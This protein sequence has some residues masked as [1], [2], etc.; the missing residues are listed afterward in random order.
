M[1][2]SLN[3]IPMSNTK[4]QFN[5]V[6]TNRESLGVP[7]AGYQSFTDIGD[8]YQNPHLFVHVPSGNRISKPWQP[9]I[10][11]L[12]DF[13]ERIYYYFIRSGYACIIWRRILEL[14]QIIFMIGFTF[15]LL[16]LVDYGILFKN[17]LP[18]R[19]N[20][21]S[22]Q[23][24]KITIN[25]CLIPLS[26]VNIPSYEVILLVF[27]GAYWA[28][29]CC[30]TILSVRDYFAIRAFFIEVLQIHDPSV[31]TWQEVQSR[32]IS[33]QSQC[34][35]REG[36]LD[37]LV[38][39]NRL[40]RRTNYMLALINKGV[41]P[42][43][44]KFPILGEVIYLS[45]GLEFNLELLLFR[46]M[47]S[48]FEKNWKLRDEVKLDRIECA[49]RFATR[50][51]VLGII[52]IIL[53]PFILVWH[54][55]YAL[56]T[57]IEAFKRDPTIFCLRTWSRYG[58]WFTR[59][60]NELDHELEQRLNRA[61]RPA[62]RYM[63]SFTSPLMTV[64]A[65]FF[66]FIAATMLSALFL[67]TVW[68]EDVITVEHVLTIVT[69]LGGVIALSRAFLPDSEPKRYTQ[70]ELDAAIVQHIH[71]RAH[72]HPAHTI[73]ARNAMSNIFVYKST[74]IIEELLSPII[75]PFIL[76][77]HLRARSLEIV[78]FFRVYTLDLADIGDVCSFS[79]FNFQQNGHRIFNDP[80][81]SNKKHDD[82]VG[83]SATS[84]G[85]KAEVLPDEPHTTRN[86]KLEL[87]LINFKLTNP[88]WQPADN[89]QAQFIERFTRQSNYDP[90]VP[91]LAH[92]NEMA[93]SH[94]TIGGGDNLQI[95]QPLTQS[96]LMKTSQ[97]H[98][99]SMQ[100]SMDRSAGGNVKLSEDFAFASKR[101][102][103]LQLRLTSMFSEKEERDNEMA[104]SSLLFHQMISDNLVQTDD[105]N[106]NMASSVSGATSTIG[107]SVSTNR[108]TRISESIPLLHPSV[109]GRD[110]SIDQ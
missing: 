19:I 105:P 15:F 68:D 21:T 16:H 96:M 64:F 29:K 25:D 66:M 87:S 104:L 7:N 102:R 51:L 82:S 31:Y 47:F 32:L 52:N 24:I 92:L 65:R 109:S 60:F 45:R 91:S 103:L 97:P 98:S 55:L 9:Y 77:R 70:A 46:G 89:G 90:M 73:Q 2:T 8:P 107:V 42:I 5:K 75:T 101:R 4:S 28:I 13:F 76:I 38:I 40:L 93:N 39:H 85:Q 1:S 6:P 95:N 27:A 34:L 44:F 22:T 48:L 35:I 3:S 54:L 26:E 33:N 108:R 79:Q 100:L 78:D 41:L 62:T 14:S 36:H 17:K 80:T 50:C 57:N 53:L 58:L 18:P 12:D 63:D 56:Y 74:T 30:E 23:P 83:V 11:D 106:P 84:V 69:G 71:Y 10:G 99:S 61:H 94:S 43:Y 67:L 86:G 88:N 72:H 49:R 37:E 81:M 59:H 20:N 110:E